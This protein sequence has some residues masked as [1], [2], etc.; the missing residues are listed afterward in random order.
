[1]ASK[2]W[3]TSFRLWALEDYYATQEV[4]GV[5]NPPG[6]SFSKAFGK[7]FRLQKISRHANTELKVEVVKMNTETFDW[8]FT[9][10]NNYIVYK[11]LG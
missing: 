2:G 11:Y 6:M 7:K 3:C 4:F 9:P 10:A 1:M 5:R 8:A